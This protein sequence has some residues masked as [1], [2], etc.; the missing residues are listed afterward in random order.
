MPPVSRKRKL[1]VQLEMSE[2]LRQRAKR[3]FGYDLPE[4]F[5]PDCPKK[6]P[7]CR[8]PQLGIY[9]SGRSGAGEQVGTPPRPGP[10]STTFGAPRSA[11]ASRH[12]PDNPHPLAGRV[13]FDSVLFLPNGEQRYGRY[14]QWGFIQHADE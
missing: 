9:K 6:E 3:K 1:A 7:V 5:K 10:D 12:G 13:C 11:P 14:D 8:A 4:G 2:T